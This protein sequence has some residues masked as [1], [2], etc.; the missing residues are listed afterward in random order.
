MTR[1]PTYKSWD[2]MKQRCSNPQDKDYVRYGGRGIT[3]HPAWLDFQV[4]LKELGLRPKGLT[5]GRIDNSLGYGPGNC[6][7][8]TPEQQGNNRRTNRFFECWGVRRTIAQ[9]AK[10]VGMS[11]QALRYRI[12]I[13]CSIET[14]LQSP[15]HHGNKFIPKK[16]LSC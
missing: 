4:F 13:G 1:T 3:V 7:W 2:S 15:L 11:R 10:Y 9:W 14:A 12:G 6:R 5:L 16:E 8:E